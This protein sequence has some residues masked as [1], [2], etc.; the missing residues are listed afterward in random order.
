METR[1]IF[2]GKRFYDLEIIF[3]DSIIPPGG[4]PEI[5]AIGSF[6]T[7]QKGTR[8]KKSDIEI[9]SERTSLQERG[10][11]MGDDF[12]EYT[13]LKKEIPQETNA[14]VICRDARSYFL[15]K[16]FVESIYARL[17]NHQTPQH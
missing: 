2:E 9:L 5:G 17:N 12:V 8:I 7:T 6:F 4:S 16:S 10:G 13:L 1:L 14:I 11:M 15:G 3:E